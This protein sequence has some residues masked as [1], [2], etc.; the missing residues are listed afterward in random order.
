MGECRGGGDHGSSNQSAVEGA[1]VIRDWIDRRYGTH[2]GFARLALAHLE[3]RFRLLDGVRSVRWDAVQRL[4]FVCQGNIARSAFADALARE[5]GM[6]SASFGLATSSGMGAHPPVVE[7][8]RE[9]GLDLSGHT[10]TAVEDYEFVE[11]DL[12]LAMEPRQVRRLRAQHRFDSVPITLLGLWGPRE[13]PHLHD[14]FG[15]SE[16]YLRTCLGRIS[17]SVQGVSAEICRAGSP[18]G[19]TSAAATSHGGPPAVGKQPS[20]A[21]HGFPRARRSP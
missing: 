16:G 12:L 11:G 1:R 3:Q 8:A 18:A 19:R 17:E 2:R 21:S 5:L 6:R 14:P 20:C 7:A 10:T 15:L 9:F 4:V 13:V